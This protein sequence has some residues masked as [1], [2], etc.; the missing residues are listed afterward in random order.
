MSKSD[1]TGKGVI[2]LSDNPELA[3]KKVM[4]ATTDSIGKI[5]YDIINQPG[6]SN[7][8]QILALLLGEE[9]DVVVKRYVGQTQY[10]ALKQ[11]VAEQVVIFL[12]AFQQKLSLVDET[13]L[14]SKLEKSEKVM[15]EQAN[16]VLFKLQKAVGLRSK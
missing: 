11:D 3:R 9:L 13:A 15:N 16:T 6:I 14:I 2:F 7:L 5:H 10:G 4:S 8:L 1:E 12:S